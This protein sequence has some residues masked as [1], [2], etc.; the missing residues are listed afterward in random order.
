MNFQEYKQLQNEIF[1]Y[2]Y[3]QE[4]IEETPE[5]LNQYVQMGSDLHLIIPFYETIRLHS[6][7]SPTF[8]YT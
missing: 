6:K 1:T 7:V 2:Y 5:R 3:G 8:C 4:E